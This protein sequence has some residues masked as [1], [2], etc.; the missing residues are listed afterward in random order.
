MTELN[1]KIPD[2]V[3]Y[4]LASAFMITAIMNGVMAFYKIKVMLWKKKLSERQ[5]KH[6]DGIMG[7]SN[8]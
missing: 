1:F 7:E 2:A 8:R 3:L 6:Y 4:I 5:Q